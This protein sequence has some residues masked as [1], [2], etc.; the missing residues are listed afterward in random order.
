MHA[1]TLPLVYGLTAAQAS[2]TA[3]FAALII[4]TLLP[5]YLGIYNATYLWIVT[6]GVD[7]VLAAAIYALWK[8]PSPPRMRLLS[9]ALKAD[10]LVGLAAI[11]FGR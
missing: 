10:M 5:F 4:A 7:L 9:A 11:Y 1:R 2:A 8:N 3:A 6:G